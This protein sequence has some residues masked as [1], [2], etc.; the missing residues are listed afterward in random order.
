MAVEGAPR[1]TTGGILAVVYLGV[2]AQ[3]VAYGLW[4]L[5]LEHVDASVAGPYVNLVPV[6]GVVLALAVGE[7]MTPVQ[8]LG[9][10]TVAVGVWL[11]HRRGAPAPAAAPARGGGGGRVLDWLRAR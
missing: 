9:G 1:V 7:T 8:I 3:A 4:N 5:A 11:N 2:L 10:L 6:V